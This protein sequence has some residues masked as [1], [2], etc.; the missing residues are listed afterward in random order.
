MGE[1]YNYFK[2]KYSKNTEVSDDIMR[3]IKVKNTLI[4]LC[5]ELKSGDVLTIEV[6]Q[7]D[8]V[9]MPVVIDEE[10]LKST[11]SIVQVDERLFEISLIEVEI[12]GI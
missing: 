11:V 9:Y 7:S 5:E 6:P 3:K 2:E 8:L 12:G 10:P 1:I 4:G